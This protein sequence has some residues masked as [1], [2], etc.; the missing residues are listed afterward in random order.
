MRQP[1]LCS[2]FCE[3]LLVDLNP[4]VL[5]WGPFWVSVWGLGVEGCRFG[6]PFGGRGLIRAPF[7]CQ[8]GVL[9]WKVAGSS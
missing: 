5:I 2:Y 9:G 3:G 6:G 7:G 4:G 1:P 8:F